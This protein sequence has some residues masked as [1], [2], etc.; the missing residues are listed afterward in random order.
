MTSYGKRCAFPTPPTAPTTGGDRSKDSIVPCAPLAP[1]GQVPQGSTHTMPDRHGPPGRSDQRRKAQQGPFPPHPGKAP[2]LA[3][4]PPTD[5]AAARPAHL[6][7]DPPPAAAAPFR[8]GAGAAPRGLRPQPAPAGSVGATGVITSRPG[9][10]AMCTRWPMPNPQST[11]HLAR[12]HNLGTG[13]PS[14]LIR[15]R[16]RLSRTA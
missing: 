1:L 8:L 5:S 7:F 3:R 9:S 11:N 4:S 12:M 6:P 2:E 13:H 15:C 16:L 10:A 14:G